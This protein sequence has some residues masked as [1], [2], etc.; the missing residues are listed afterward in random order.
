MSTRNRRSRGIA[1]VALLSLALA[2]CSGTGAT[3]TEAAVATTTTTAAEADASTTTTAAVAEEPVILTVSNL[4]PATE[5]STREAFLAQVAAFEEKYPNIDIEP[6]EY[7]WDPATFGAQLAGGTLPTLFQI[8]F[9]DAQGLIA[10]GQLADITDLV[11]ELPYADDLNPNVLAVTQDADG[12]IYG[13][14]TAAYGIGLHYNRALFEQAGLDPDSPPQTWDEVREYAAAIA[15]ETGQA[16][17]AQMSQSNTGGWMLTSLTYAFGGRM[18][19]GTGDD[20]SATIANEGTRQ[21]L[22]TLSAMRWEDDSLGDNFLYDWGTIN[23]AFAAGQ[24]GMYMSGSDVYNSLVTENAID[25][26]SYGLTVIPLAGED[27]G[28]LAGGT[29]VA[30]KSSAS[31]AEID[32][33]VKWLDFFYMAKLVDEEAAI[34]DAEALVANG[35]PLGTPALPIFDEDQLALSDSWVADYVNVPLEQMRFFKDGILTQP[36]V[37]EPAAH[38]QELYAILDTVVQTVMTQQDADLD[39]LLQDADAQVNQLLESS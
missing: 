26:A 5:A 15:A 35:A 39:A 18:Q 11:A 29:V 14:A 13:L 34:G 22:E 8:P 1:L 19:D 23:Q 32:A 10:D 25:P 28:V 30:V 27:A 31:E 33:A 16:G 24:I 38:A 12:R 20:I 6:S 4:P 7:E 17:Y 2:A 9:T 3:T 37:P 36:L 21:A